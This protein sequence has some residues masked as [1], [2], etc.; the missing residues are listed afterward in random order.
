MAHKLSASALSLFLK[1]PRAFYWRYKAGLEPVAPSVTTYD[2]DKVCGLVW[3]EAV[4]RFYMGV[5]EQ[6]NT[7][8]T[9]STFDTQTD[10]WVPSK[11]KERLVNALTA[12]CSAY[13][14]QF[15]PED[16]VRTQ[17]EVYLENDK[18]LGFL[19]GLNEKGVVH[20]VKSTSR[21]PQLSGQLWRVENSIQVK[22]Y[23]VL[24]DASGYQIE[25]AFKDSPHALFRAPVVEVSTEQ[26]RGWKQALDNLAD[27]IYSLGDD[28][29]NY[30]CN[31]DSCCM[32]SK[33]VTSLCQYMPLCDQ[34][35][36]AEIAFKPRESRR[37]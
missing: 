3:S 17:S 4:E 15:S 11:A 9:L 14:Q 16:G 33:G 23:C 31:S 37:K 13:Y 7:R 22:L 24:A 34:V 1:S 10:G 36:G 8:V 12:W 26:K 25:F 5:P 19:D 2:H 27:Y 18:F 20:E 32:A 35:P 29:N 6:E 28:P 30:V 21:S